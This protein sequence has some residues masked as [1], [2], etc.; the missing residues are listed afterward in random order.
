M[1]WQQVE[2]GRPNVL[3]TWEG[4]GG[5]SSLMLNGHMDTSYSGREPWLAGIPGFQPQG[6]VEDGRVYG[7]GDLE[8]EGCAGLLRGSAARSAGRR[9]EAPRAISCSRPSAERSRRLSGARRRAPNTEATPPAPGTSS[10]TAVSRRRASSASRPR[11]RSCSATSARSG[12][13]SP[14]VA[15][16]FTRRSARAGAARTRSSG[17]VRSSTPCSSGSRPGRTTRRTP[18]AERGRS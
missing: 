6:F 13:A 8:H 15:T 4:T 18:T 3:A 16:S 10:R 2:D 12:F 5:G 14:R 11:G 17:C 7:L 9:R 1:H